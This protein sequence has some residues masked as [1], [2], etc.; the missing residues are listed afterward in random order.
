MEQY[1]FSLNFILFVAN[2][3]FSP[4]C[5][6]VT[7]RTIKFSSTRGQQ[8]AIKNGDSELVKKIFVFLS[9][10]PVSISALCSTKQDFAI[11]MISS[12]R[13]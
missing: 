2:D 12:V 7:G 6:P 11:K 3:S 4:V 1:P 5:A 9:L 13:I 8:K 10:I